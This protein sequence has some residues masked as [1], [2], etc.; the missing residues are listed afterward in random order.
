MEKTLI[1]V[2]IPSH[3]AASTIQEAL[4]S[5][6]HQ[7][8]KNIEII[9]IDDLS[10]DNTQNVVLKIAQTDS[11]IKYY[12]IPYNDEE[13]VNK[14]GRN[15]NAGYSARNYGF[16]KAKGDYITFQ[17]AD[18]ASFNNR[19]EVQ[20]DLLVKHK[21]VHVV[22]DWQKFD[23]NLLNKN[24]DAAN[25]L[26]NNPHT[27]KPRE[28]EMLAKK[29]RGYIHMFPNISKKISF[30]IKRT[31]IIN[32][33]FF[34]S[35]TPYP[36]TGNSP[37]FKREVIEKVIFR[38]LSDRIWPSFTGRGADRDFNFQVALTFKNSYVFKLP[39][40]LWRSEKQNPDYENV[41]GYVL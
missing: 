9:V 8:Y 18:D 20:Y 4:F 25:F 39:L 2:I 6:T 21:A 34:R 19:I 40:Y 7:T 32:K 37:L 22:L 14:R 3:N 13:R 5:M 24:F 41:S 28:L 17:D 38:K 1:S 23:T 29:T 27:I 31:K 35:L 33:L 36:G 10:T 15:I 12:K 30:E 11:R 26:A 16:E